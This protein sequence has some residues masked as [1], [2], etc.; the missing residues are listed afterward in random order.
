LLTQVAHAVLRTRKRPAGFHDQA[1]L[2]HF[3]CKGRIAGCKQLPLLLALLGRMDEPATWRAAAVLCSVARQPELAH[4]LEPAL[5][6]LMAVLR[7]PRPR[8]AAARQVRPRRQRPACA[9]SP[10]T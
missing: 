4:G 5:A 1:P 9:A 10:I 7:E 8:G 2:D 6:R 3:L